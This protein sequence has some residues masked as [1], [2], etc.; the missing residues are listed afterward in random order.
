MQ[1]GC[2]G[3]TTRSPGSRPARVAD[4][5]DLRHALVA[6]REGTIERRYAS[7]DR[8]VEITSGR[9]DRPHDRVVVGAQPRLRDLTELN[10]T[11]TN[12]RQLAHGERHNVKP[13]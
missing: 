2:Q 11:A 6:D 4:L 9:G 12:E 8:A 10:L 3:T 1:Q 13:V 5:D 7:D